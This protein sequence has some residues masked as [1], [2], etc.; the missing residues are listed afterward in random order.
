MLYKESNR[1][2]CSNYRGISRVLR[3]GEVLLK[4]VA[5]RLS[6]HCEAHGILPEERRG[7]RPDR[8]TCSLYRA[9]SRNWDN[10]RECQYTCASSTE[11]F[12]DRCLP[13]LEFR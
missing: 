9:N 7:F 5:Y 1:P 11:D 2:N 10:D 3:A 4:M 8:S 12:Y 6:D 13:A